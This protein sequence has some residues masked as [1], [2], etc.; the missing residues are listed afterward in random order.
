MSSLLL[1]LFPL[2]LVLFP[3]Q[4]LPLHIFEQRY[5]E[6]IGE[7]LEQHT[8]FGVVLSKENSIVNIGCTSVVTDVAKRYDDGRLDIHT[9]GRRRF[10]VLFLDQERAFLRGAV[11]FFDDDSEE[12][13]AELRGK[14]IALHHEVIDLLV[15][16]EAERGNLR[17]SP[18]APR[19]SFPMI[20]P[21]P[22]DVD[23]KQVLLAMR[24]EAE[25]LDRL[26]D[27]F[28]QLIVRLRLVA[29]V[30]QRA[31]KNGHGR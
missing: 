25:R 20:G 2:E 15:S 14:A 8:E 9:E 18:E 5:K 27:Y 7:C 28:G 1:P 11:Q 24:N 3:G 23:F 26:V 31:G 12:A 29:Q 10:E 30:K 21:L 17:V 16:D 4:H 22:V 19:L 6:M 13:P